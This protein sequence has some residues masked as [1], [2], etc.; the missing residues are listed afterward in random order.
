MNTA[1]RRRFITDGY[2]TVRRAVPKTMIERAR[3]LINRRLGEKGR[4]ATT[5]DR[6]AFFADD[7]HAPELTEL[8][9]AT[10][11]WAHAE[12]LIGPGCVERPQAEVTLG[13]PN[14]DGQTAFNGKEFH[15]DGFPDKGRYQET[16][17]LNIGIFLSDV[18]A[19][20]R[21]NFVACPGSHIEV[22][23]YARQHGV[24][25]INEALRGRTY[26][27]RRQLLVKAG[28]AVLC[29]YNTVHARQWNS[30]ADI[31][32]AVFFRVKRVGHLERWREALAEPW[33]EWD[34]LR[35]LAARSP[36]SGTEPPEAQV[37]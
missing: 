24:E 19:E 5:P 28:D 25:G 37:P 14:P 7:F 9:L 23:R 11:L 34:G 2:M 32:Y 22:A 31:R 36:A 27:R 26:P 21:G 4:E 10:P 18:V 30:T 1:W 17:T 13:F 6:V 16:Y 33:L 8:L 3:R 12:A 15:I 29:H 35:D 20:D